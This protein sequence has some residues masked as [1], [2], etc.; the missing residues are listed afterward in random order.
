MPDKTTAVCFT[1]RRP[2]D[3]GGYVHK[4]Y[5]GLLRFL[6]EYIEAELCPYKARF[7]T[8][9]AQGFDQ[10]VFWAVASVKTTAKLPMENALYLPFPSQDRNWSAT[11]PFGREEYG[12][13]KRNATEIKYIS[14]KN[15]DGYRDAVKFLM[16]RNSAM[17]ADADTCIGLWTDD[18]AWQDPNMRSG[19]AAC[20]R[21][22][23]KKCGHVQIIRY[24]MD[25][26]YVRPLRADIVK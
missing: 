8:G 26:Q 13:M 3:L 2:K 1:G 16:A 7:I 11:G 17:L 4:N 18:D 20:L 12:L 21:D 25:G 19:T 10:L 5:D 22:A 14:D 23:V 15:P 6:Q 9:G 24:E